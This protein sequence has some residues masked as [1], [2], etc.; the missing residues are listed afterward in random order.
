MTLKL[1]EVNSIEG[2]SGEVLIIVNRF[3]TMGLDLT[4]M[5]KPIAAMN[6]ALAKAQTLDEVYKAA[7]NY[8]DKLMQ[9]E[10]HLADDS[11]KLDIL[12]TNK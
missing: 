12:K 11:E 7:I 4:N 1:K 8:N 5:Q 10:K 6:S 2:E 9:I 3:R